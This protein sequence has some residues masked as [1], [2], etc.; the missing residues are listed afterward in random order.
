MTHRSSFRALRLAFALIVAVPCAG[1]AARLRAQ[2]PGQTPAVPYVQLSESDAREWLTYLS[3][4]ALEGRQVFS[5]GYGMAAAYVADHLRQWGVKPLG[6][7]GTY[8]QTVR[9]NG[10]RVTRRS[11]ITVEAN[12]QSRTFSAGDHVVFPADAGGKQT[13]TFDSLE[14]AGYGGLTPDGPVVDD[15][16]PGDSR[17]A[18]RLVMYMSG[19]EI[20]RGAARRRSSQPKLFDD[21]HAAGSVTFMAGITPSSGA[22]APSRPGGSRN[23]EIVTVERIDALKPPQITADAALFDALFAGHAPGFAELQEK[24]SRGEALPGFTLKNVRV[25]IHVDNE[26]SIVS[27]KLT[28][29]VVGLIEGTDAVLKDTYVFIGA[30]LDHVGYSAGRPAQEAN[31]REPR[32]GDTIFNGAD[33]DG[34]GSTAVLLIAKALATGPRPKRSVVVVWHSGEEAGLLGSS[35]MA[36][37]PVVPLDQVQAELNIDMIGRNRDDDPRQADTVYL[38]GADR[39]STDLHNLVIETNNRLPKALDIDFEFND[40]DDPN[41][42]YTR[43]D[44]Y[45]YAQKGIPVA[46][47]FTGDHPDYHCVSDEVDRILFP[48]LIRVAQLIYEAGFNVADSSRDLV[49]DQRG[50]RTGRGSPATVLN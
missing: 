16:R 8:F 27:T 4:D 43:S 24:A 23:A 36:D 5:E 25:T 9:Q 38:V 42:F 18:G 41:S 26:Y 47:F 46:F 28:D 17:L 44:H 22:A 1:T 35:Y 19:A 12:G 10:Y 45:S 7:Q 32:P 30:H 21:L 31:C 14:F 37:F 13:L 48:K 11:S 40:P 33:D 49:R 20:G 29:N 39:I 6:D 3:S 15:S 2:S 34:S 50:P